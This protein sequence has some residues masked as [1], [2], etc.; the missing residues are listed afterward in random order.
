M[1]MARATHRSGLIFLLLGV[2][3]GLFFWATDPRLGPRGHRI[4]LG[5]MD[6]RYWL[7]LLRGSPDSVLDAAN[8]ALLSTA[9]GLAGSVALLLVGLWLLTRR[10]I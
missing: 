8:H 1:S 4:A 7:F 6:W 10:S 3:G 5:H 9:V 2:I